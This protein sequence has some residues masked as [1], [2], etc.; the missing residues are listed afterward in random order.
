MSDKSI[1][2][3]K[4]QAGINVY[5]DDGEI[6]ISQIDGENGERHFIHVSPMNIDKFISLLR[7]AIQKINSDRININPSEK[8]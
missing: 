7:E 1:G 2:C 6:F 3:I 5:I 8:F 4:S